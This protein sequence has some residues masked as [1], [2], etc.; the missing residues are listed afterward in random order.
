MCFYL[1]VHI[2]VRTGTLLLHLIRTLILC[3]TP[4]T[5]VVLHT[6]VLQN[7]VQPFRGLAAGCQSTP[8]EQT[9]E[10]K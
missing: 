2:F 10:A 7:A 5:V 8:E 6:Q 9:N 1:V 3:A 4:E